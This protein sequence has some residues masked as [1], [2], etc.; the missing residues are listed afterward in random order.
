MTF[1][2]Y[3]N[4]TLN[5]INNRPWNTLLCFEFAYLTL[6]FKYPW[7]CSQYMVCSDTKNEMEK[8]FLLLY[9]SEIIFKKMEKNKAIGLDL[10]L[11]FMGLKWW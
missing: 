7:N 8:M 10:S 6:V 9:C 1:E 3:Q 2:N 4:F 5:Q 11:D